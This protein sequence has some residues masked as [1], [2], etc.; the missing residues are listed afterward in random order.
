MGRDLARLQ[1]VFM[2]MWLNLDDDDEADC[3]RD[4]IFS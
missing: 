4:S 1:E 3:N 2:K